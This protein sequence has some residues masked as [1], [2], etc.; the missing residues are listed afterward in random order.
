M[1]LLDLAIQ[2]FN[3][4]IYPFSHFAPKSVAAS[5]S[6]IVTYNRKNFVGADKF[7]LKVVTPKEFLQEIGELK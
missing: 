1:L 7:G 6:Y 5:S 3:G 4:Q 2:R